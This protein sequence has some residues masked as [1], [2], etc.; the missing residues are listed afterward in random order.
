M[1]AGGQKESVCG[2]RR[3]TSKTAVEI[4]GSTGTGVGGIEQKEALVVLEVGG[5]AR[6]TAYHE[7]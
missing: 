3:A 2:G 6:V 1:V 5:G 7:L 4:A